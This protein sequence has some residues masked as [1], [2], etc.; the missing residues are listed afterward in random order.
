MVRVQG[1][2]LNQIISRRCYKEKSFF[3]RS[4]IDNNNSIN[5]VSGHFAMET[6]QLSEKKPVGFLTFDIEATGANVFT[7]K[8]LAIGWA[9]GS[10]SGD[11]VTGKIC[12]DL[13]KPTN[14]LWE[15]LWKE[16]GWETRCWTEFWSKY[17]DVLD[18]LQVP[19]LISDSKGMAWVV[20]NVLQVVDDTFERYTIVSDTLAF[21]SVWITNLLHEHGYHGLMYRRDGSYNRG[22]GGIEV[23]SYL[24]GVYG[25]QLDDL[26]G[27]KDDPWSRD[28]LYIHAPSP[29]HD[30]D[31]ENDAHHI[32]CSL[33]NALN[34]NS[35]FK[36]KRDS[37]QSDTH[38][39]TEESKRPRLILGEKNQCTRLQDNLEE[40]L[41]EE[42]DTKKA[43][44][45]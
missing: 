5:I 14:T 20:N 23:D 30:H 10:C 31:P 34:A 33:F 18:G 15:D 40:G 12:L 7:N 16:R 9:Y 43:D 21:D 35:R 1:V 24:M 3:F 28:P 39:E 36:R 37:A 29:P 42:S 32:L 41:S 38:S 4:T 11:V 27:R 22:I 26:E 6:P 17:T 2:L 25:V 44:T 45:N 13:N 8:M 19:D